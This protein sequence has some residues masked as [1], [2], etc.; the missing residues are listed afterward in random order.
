MNARSICLG[1]I[2]TSL[3][4]GW[5]DFSRGLTI[6]NL[7]I[8]DTSGFNVRVSEPTGIGT[9]NETHNLVDIAGDPWVSSSTIFEDAGNSLFGFSDTLDITWNIQHAQGPHGLDVNPNPTA[10]MLNLSFTPTAAGAFTSISAPINVDHPVSAGNA[11]IDRFALRLSGMAS[12][13]NSA[14]NIDSYV[15]DYI[16][17]HDNVDGANWP[18]ALNPTAAQNYGNFPDNMPQ[19][20][21]GGVDIPAPAGTPVRAVLGGTITAVAPVMAGSCTQGCFFEVT[22]AVGNIHSYTHVKKLDGADFTATDIG[23]P[24]LEGEAIALVRSAADGNAGSFRHTHYDYIPSPGTFPNGVVNA[25]LQILPTKDPGGNAPTIG[26]IF[27]QPKGG[28]V[29][30][31]VEFGQAPANMAVRRG[32]FINGR[33]D[34]IE[35]IR[36]NQGAEPFVGNR[37][38]PIDGTVN[39]YNGLMSNPHQVSYQVMGQGVVAGRNI[40]ERTLV[41]FN[42][43]FGTQNPVVVA[44]QVYDTRR[45]TT[46][47]GTNARNYMYILTNT[48]NVGP[49]QANEW[50]TLAKQGAASPDGT[51]AA[52]AANNGE[53][54]FP[55]GIYEVRGFGFDIGANGNPANKTSVPYQVRMNN[56]KQTAVPNKGGAIAPNPVRADD[57]FN[58]A[59]NEQSSAALFETFNLAEDI[60]GTGDNY[61]SAMNYPWF[62]FNHKVNWSQGDLFNAPLLTGLL[63]GSDATGHIPNTFLATAVNLGVGHYDLAYDIGRAYT[64][65]ESKSISQKL[66]HFRS[67]AQIGTYWQLGAK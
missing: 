56:W 18:L 41:R 60:F 7:L 47:V 53:A 2:T 62:I 42:G 39:I 14:F 52:A 27:Y 16:A 64:T 4:F 5:T 50:N 49:N 24:V 44:Q 34:L 28:N 37:A 19:S 51:G 65:T 48:N 36:D 57:V 23:S 59:G 11:H 10:S 32:T 26:P 9:F 54:L 30:G 35:E 40:P 21:H 31:F 38:D 55:D 12:A 63:G 17:A 61:L 45:D 25:L 3:T 43:N 66:T 46:T 8:N 29:A 58:L 33:I 1:L 67:G 15:I 13:A 22:D 20:L 6:S